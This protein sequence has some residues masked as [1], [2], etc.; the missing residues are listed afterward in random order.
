MNVVISITPFMLKLMVLFLM[1]VVLIVMIMILLLLLSVMYVLPL[2]SQVVEL[3][4]LRMHTVLIVLVFSGLT[5]LVLRLNKYSIM[6][7]LV[8]VR[9]NVLLHGLYLTVQ[10]VL[11]LMDFLITISVSVVLMTMNL[12][13]TEF[14][15]VT[16]QMSTEILLVPLLLV[17]VNLL[18]IL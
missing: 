1:I 15:A 17:N 10:A 9:T 13:L 18:M 3:I 8:I 14:V 4:L 5:L 7:K 16:N 12:M 11:V 2:D 6:N